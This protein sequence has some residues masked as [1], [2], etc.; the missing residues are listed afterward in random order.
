MIAHGCRRLSRRSQVCMWSGCLKSHSTCISVACATIAMD[1][2]MEHNLSRRLLEPGVGM[3][4][5][6][7][8]LEEENSGLIRWF[9]SPP[10]VVS[11]KT[12]VGKWCGVKSGRTALLDVGFLC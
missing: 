4:E 10:N 7:A 9:F 5:I 11:P 1:S 2:W 8:H 12:I 6:P 3:V